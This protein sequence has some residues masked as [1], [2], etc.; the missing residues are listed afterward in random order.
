V[1][2]RRSPAG[3]RLLEINGRFSSLVAFRALCGFRD[4]EWSLAH[5]L[6]HVPEPPVGPYRAL[7]FRRFFHELVDDGDG[8]EAV[9]RWLPRVGA[10]AGLGNPS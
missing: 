8:Y 4:V 2:V 9:D 3:I 6:G 7:R 1:Q 10:P 5:A